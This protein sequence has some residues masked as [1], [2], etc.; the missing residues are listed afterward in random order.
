MLTKATPS[1]ARLEA[2]LCTL[3]HKFGIC[4][5]RFLL[6]LHQQQSAPRIL[7]HQSQTYVSI[8]HR[9]KLQFTVKA[10]DSTQATSTAGKPVVPDD[11][12]SLTKV[13]PLDISVYQFSRFL[14]LSRFSKQS[15][16]AD[17]IWCCWIKRWSILTDVSFFILS[18]STFRPI[19]E[20]NFLPQK[21]KLSWIM[22]LW[23]WSLLQYTSW[24]GMVGAYANLR[25]SACNYWYGSQG[26]FLLPS[27]LQL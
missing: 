6:S 11:G 4:D 27:W 25:F 2:V 18:I 22:Q 1:P 26:K 12:F 23:L 19:V 5:R 8:S 15:I 24:I 14:L 20:F 10:A 9:H 16:P 3:D 17:L 7:Q 13:R 21:L